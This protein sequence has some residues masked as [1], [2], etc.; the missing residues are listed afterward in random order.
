MIHARKDYD[1]IQ[2]P[3]GVIPLD[4]PV[5]LV[6]GQDPVGYLVV[7]EWAQLHAEAALAA[8]ASPQDIQPLMNAIH[9]HT[10]K[11]QLWAKNAGH[12]PATVDENQLRLF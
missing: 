3:D 2:D 7:R 11:M 4:E 12:G 1:R 9:I 5:F 8:G 6:R 10:T